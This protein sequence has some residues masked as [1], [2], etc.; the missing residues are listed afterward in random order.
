MLPSFLS[1]VEVL[2]P[3]L[4]ITDEVHLII[5]AKVRDATPALQRCAVMT[6]AHGRPRIRLDTC[7]VPWEGLLLGTLSRNSC[8]W[9]RMGLR[10]AML[11]CVCASLMGRSARRGKSVVWPGERDVVHV[12]RELCGGSWC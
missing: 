7:F 9:W 10:S 12:F 11:R 1:I 6:S 2:R 8:T 4:Q 5:R 3:M